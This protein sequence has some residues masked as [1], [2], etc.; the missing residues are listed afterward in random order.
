M[1]R[2]KKA[3]S[4][5]QYTHPLLG[6]GAALQTYVNS[7]VCVAQRGS[8]S[9]TSTPCSGCGSHSVRNDAAPPFA[10]VIPEE[11]PC[12]RLCQPPVLHGCGAPLG[13]EVSRV[14]DRSDRN[15]P[16]WDVLKFPTIST[17]S[18]RSVPT[19]STVLVVVRYDLEARKGEGRSPGFRFLKDP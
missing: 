13:G 7:S 1:A 2:E 17:A 9:S 12:V 16:G 4:S 19:M 15:A 18:V 6:S 10:S 5:S 3:Y 11:K 14:R 8:E